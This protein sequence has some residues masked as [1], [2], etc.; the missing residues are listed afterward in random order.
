MDSYIQKLRKVD[1]NKL[2]R[3]TRLVAQVLCYGHCQRSLSSSRWSREKYRPPS[4]TLGPDQIN[5]QTSC[6]YSTI[7]DYYAIEVE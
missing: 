5:H 7:N 4:H 3:K 1:T 2:A 6:L